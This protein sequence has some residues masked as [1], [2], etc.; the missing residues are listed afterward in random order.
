MHCQ[1]VR[2]RSN[3]VARV[4]DPGFVA[5]VPSELDLQTISK[6]YLLQLCMDW[7][8][9]QAIAFVPCAGGV[10]EYGSR[11]SWEGFADR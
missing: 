3:M 7:V 11:V 1:K 2:A 9:L 10:V 8:T 5:F 4:L 6:W